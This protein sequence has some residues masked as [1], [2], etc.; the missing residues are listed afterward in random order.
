MNA[1][2]KYHAHLD[3]CERC[4]TRP[5]DQCAVGNRLLEAAGREGEKALGVL[6]EIDRPKKQAGA[7]C[8]R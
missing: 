2:E 4:R 7:R 5:F 3:A 6:P 1:G 8:A